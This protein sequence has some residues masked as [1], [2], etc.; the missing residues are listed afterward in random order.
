[1]PKYKVGDYVT[2]AVAIAAD[3]I[4]RVTEIDQQTDPQHYGTLYLCEWNWDPASHNTAGWFAEHELNPAP[5]PK[6]LPMTTPT[7]TPKY[8]AGDRVTVD[9]C[10]DMVVMRV[11]P[12][13]AGSS[14]FG[15]WCA[16]LPEATSQKWYPE[17]RLSLASTTQTTLT[18]AKSPKYW[19]GDRVTPTKGLPG[20]GT[21]FTITRVAIWPDRSPCY[22]WDKPD[23]SGS[24]WCSEHELEPAPAETK[25]PPI[26]RGC[27]VRTCDSNKTG[28]V[29]AFGAEKSNLEG[30]VC[31]L[32]PNGFLEWHDVANVVP[33]P[34][35]TPPRFKVFDIDAWYMERKLMTEGSTP[36]VNTPATDAP[37]TAGDIVRL[38]SGSPPMTVECTDHDSDGEPHARVTWYDDARCELQGATLPTAALTRCTADAAAV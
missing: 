3:A 12:A 22:F 8:K 6:A 35:E 7:P 33:M 15:Y 32:F 4:M 23:G 25:T 21:P 38:K 5:P 36:P 19:V 37:I 13:G 29:I 17:S 30:H 10:R 9:G 34:N 27:R 28:T 2:K 14:A 24:V 31:V 16:R 18:E 1:M 20:A 11:E 26:T